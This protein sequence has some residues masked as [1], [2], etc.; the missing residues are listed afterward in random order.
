MVLSIVE[1]AGV[2]CDGVV[3]DLACEIGSTHN[4]GPQ[5]F[6]IKSARKMTRE[7]CDRSQHE[8]PASSG[9]RW[10]CD[11]R[12]VVP[13]R[14]RSTPVPRGRLA[15]CYRQPVSTFRQGKDLLDRATDEVLAGLDI[16]QREILHRLAV[17]AIDAL[18]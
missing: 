15:G 6:A 17:Q 5:R 11:Q 4:F 14:G 9:P 7:Y 16:D 2:A 18:Y 1:L 8:G 12:S 10:R 13:R 3:D